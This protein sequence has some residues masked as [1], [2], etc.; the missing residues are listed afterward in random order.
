MLSYV[1]MHTRAFACLLDKR[2]CFP[3][4]LGARLCSTGQRSP[5]MEGFFFSQRAQLLGSHIRCSLRSLLLACCLCFYSLNRLIAQS[6]ESVLPYIP[7]LWLYSC[8]CLSDL[9]KSKTVSG[10]SSPFSRAGKAVSESQAVMWF[11]FLYS[12]FIFLWKVIKYSIFP[13]L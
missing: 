2:L 13:L 12:V 10:F 1:E 7:R 6:K 9:E 3:W 11:F 4:S 5:R 8:L